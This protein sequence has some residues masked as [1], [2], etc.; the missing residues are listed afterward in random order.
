[1]LS[2]YVILGFHGRL[3]IN[4]SG[5][6]SVRLC[7]QLLQVNIVL[8]LNVGLLRLFLTLTMHTMIR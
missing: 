2:D 5:R 4:R 8:V 6:K 7:L 1:V 3:L